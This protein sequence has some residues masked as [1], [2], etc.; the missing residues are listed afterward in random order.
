MER[1][2]LDRV[3]HLSVGVNLCPD[4]NNFTES[5]FRYVLDVDRQVVERLDMKLFNV[6]HDQGTCV[7]NPVVKEKTYC[8]S[9]FAWINQRFRRV[10][11]PQ[12]YRN[13]S[14]QHV[15]STSYDPRNAIE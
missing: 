8:A 6:A 4:R 13:D 15:E 10:D 1:H 5:H 14:S 11:D 9:Q 12:F 2:Q 7:Y 3:K